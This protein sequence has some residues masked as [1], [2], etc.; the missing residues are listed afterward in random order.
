MSNRQETSSRWGRRHSF[1]KRLRSYREQLARLTAHRS[2][3]RLL[4]GGAISALGD[5]IGYI[6]FLAAVTH[7]SS[8][9]MA[10]GMLTISETLPAII[11][12]PIV[13]LIVDRIDRRKLMFWSDIARAVFFLIAAF[14]PEPWMLYLTAFASAAFTV[15]FE[16]SRQAL[17]PHY[18]P[19]GEIT[20]ATG[21]RMSLMSTVMI[22]GPAIGGVLAGSVGFK[23]AFLINACSFLVSA[24]LVSDLDPVERDA[25]QKSE[26]AWA[27]LT[28]GFRLVRDNRSLSFLFV[29][30]GVFT[31]VI[32][33]QFPLI[34][35]FVKEVLKGGP[36]EAGWLFSAIGIGGLI[37]G[38]AL[39]ALKKEN[40][41]FDVSTMRGKRNIA[42]L[43]A[44][45]GFVVVL[46]ALQTA[47]L[48]SM[49]IFAVF[50][51][52]GT[53]FH[54]AF[55]AAVAS[56]SPE[57]L[58]GRVFALHAAMHGPLMVVSIAVGAPLAEQYG[59]QAVFHVSGLL[60]VLIGAGGVIWAMR[61]QS[62]HTV[63]PVSDSYAVRVSFT[64][65]R[66]P[67]KEG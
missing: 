32:G 62:R 38:G 26:S 39:A 45:D 12:V 33:I 53:A 57:H 52:I 49:I 21:I 27:E 61:A 65:L 25:Q 41:P 17:E 46:F 1:V 20:Q 6:A 42:L 5:R 55:S 7:A 43:A 10:V 47:L 34:Y 4:L 24:Y 30:F 63:E 51:F 9:V 28:G 36:G 48:P 50:G 19:E 11:A 44:L 37:G 14:Y 64:P 22:L 16:P 13:S 2:Y 67:D 60:E 23:Y 66:S 54:T 8:G 40:N 56:E 3:R 18:V 31:L 29:L 15:L 58:R 59:S 35:V